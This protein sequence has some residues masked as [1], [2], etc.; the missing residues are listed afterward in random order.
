MKRKLV[1]G[2]IIFAIVCIIVSLSLWKWFPFKNKAYQTLVRSEIEKAK[3]HFSEGG[4][5]GA[6]VLFV[7][8]TSF[9]ESYQHWIPKICPYRKY[10]ILETRIIV[11]S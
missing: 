3:A 9:G 2:F 7:G 11:Y 1:V 10:E 4:Q 6:R 5:K 8:D